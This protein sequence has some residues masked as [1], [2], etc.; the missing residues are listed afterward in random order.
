VAIGACA[1]SMSFATPSSQLPS[2]V[3]VGRDVVELQLLFTSSSEVPFASVYYRR[4]RFNARVQNGRT[5]PTLGERER[6]F[7]FK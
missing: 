7:K 1:V 6:V 3:D 2:D 5:R 4:A